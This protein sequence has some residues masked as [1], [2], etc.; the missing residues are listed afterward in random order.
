MQNG[1]HRPDWTVLATVQA[2][3][4]YDSLILTYGNVAQSGDPLP[5][6]FANRLSAGD[7]LFESGS[8][9]GA[10][11]SHEVGIKSGHCDGC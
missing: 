7:I 10:N 2:G 6:P 3:S 5:L 9:G 11:E 8:P 4:T 1:P